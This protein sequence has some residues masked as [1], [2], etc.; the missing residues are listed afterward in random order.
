MQRS[1]IRGG[2]PAFRFAPC[3]LQGRQRCAVVQLSRPAAGV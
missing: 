1:E 2:R 3:G